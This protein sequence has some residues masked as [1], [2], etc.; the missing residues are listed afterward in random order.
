[1]NNE[2]DFEKIL[3]QVANY[4]V[5]KT[6][7][8]AILETKPSSN[9]QKVTQL[10]AETEQA[11]NILDSG[12]HMPFIGSEDIDHLFQKI[13]KGLILKPN[14]FEKIADFLR[15][16]TLL[17][18]FFKRNFELAPMLNSYAQGLVLFSDLENEIY[19]TIEHDQVSD[20]VSNDLLRMRRESRELDDRI[21]DGLNQF[22]T[23]KKYAS[24]LQ[25]SLIII[26][27]NHYTIPIKSSFKNQISG[28]IY[29]SSNN[30]TTVYIEPAK[31]ASLNQ[32]KALLQ[33]QIESLELT[34]L[35]NLTAKIYDQLI[36]LRQNLEI[37]LEL[38]KIMAR[39]KYAHHLNA[40]KPAINRQNELILN[41]VRHPLIENAVPLSLELNQSNS[42]L[43]ITGPNAGGKTVTLKTIGL[44]ILMTESGLFLPGKE[45]NIPLVDNVFVLIGDYQSIDNS[46]S[47]FSA[48]MSHISKICQK[49]QIRSLILLDELGTGTDPNEGSA[50]AIGVLQELYLRGCL[51]VG[52]THY[53]MIKDF[54]VNHDE[55]LTAEMD[56]D[57]ETLKPTYR[58]ILNR[59][60][61]SR[62]LW[63][64]EKSGMSKTII[65]NAKRIMDGHSYP[66]KIKK[67]KIT[68]K[69]DKEKQAPKFHKG[70]IVY[71]GNLG[72][73]GIFYEQKFGTDQIILF[74]DKEFRMIPMK[75]AKLRRK[76]IDLYPKGYNLD[77]LFIKDW[78]EY[79]FNKDLDRGS[80]KAYKKLK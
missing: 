64:A 13:D 70:D 56:F 21:K 28:Q 48:E 77:Q 79:K 35:G 30:K 45:S 44:M 6:A 8:K 61:D 42:V 33:S 52:T 76:A 74:I 5:T 60:G 23:S 11:T 3:E 29:G 22:I 15:I 47:T 67:Q 16:L 71:A 40:V 62:A 36:I 57:V 27:N 10:L 46:L 18:R 34:I 80:K 43:M 54:A 31:I 32:R 19:Q 73:E 50:I 69:K 59:V 39:A 24:M 4:A 26:R 20:R 9:F 75:R 68:V 72:R 58:L 65:K 17:Q 37:I 41:Q 53:S 78:Q 12:Q 55:F 38:D 14:E 7:K 49:A 51:V 25:D 2:L 63:I 66:Y 1:M